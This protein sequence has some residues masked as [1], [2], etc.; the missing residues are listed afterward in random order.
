[1]STPIE[2]KV[3]AGT[4]GSG[5]G[6]VLSQLLLWIIGVTAY[7]VS[8]SSASAMKAIAAVPDPV[9]IFLTLVVTVGLGFTGG[10]LAKHSPR[11]AEELNAAGDEA[12]TELSAYP[13]YSPAANP[14]QQV[15]DEDHAAEIATPEALPKG[16][17]SVMGS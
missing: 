2:S 4:A 10:Y 5:T 9:S 8:A 15:T 12:A 6:Y 16:G 3:W 17:S 11:T 13:A 7:S 14:R 1:M